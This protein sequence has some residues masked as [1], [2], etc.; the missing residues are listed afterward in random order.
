MYYNIKYSI[1]KDQLSLIKD[2]QNKLLYS[3]YC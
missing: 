3:R 2:N 1:F